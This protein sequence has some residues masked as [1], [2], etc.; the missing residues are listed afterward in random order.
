MATVRLR[1]AT[2]VACLLATLATAPA[3]MRGKSTHV[4]LPADLS[5][6]H[7]GSAYR[8]RVP[9]NWNGTLLVYAHGTRLR[10]VSGPVV[11]EIAPPPY[12][13]PA[14][15][16]EDQLLARGYALAG[17]EYASSVTNGT[18]ATH[19]LTEYFNGAVGRPSRVLIWGCSLGGTVTTLLV[20]KYPN[21]YDGGVSCASGSN[22]MKAND[23][24]LAF[25]LAYDV[26]FG[27]PADQWGPLEDVRDDL[28]F[29]QDVAPIFKTQ[30]PVTPDKLAKWEFIRLVTKFSQNAFW[31]ADP[32]L[33]VQFFALALWRA[34]EQRANAEAAFGGP[35]SQN[36]DHVYTLTAGEKAYLASL[37]MTNAD[38]LLAEMNA[39]TNIEAD[40]STRR[41]Q[42]IWSA[43]GVLTRPL[44]TM[45]SAYDGLARTEAENLFLAE[46]LR[47]GRQDSLVQ[48]YTALPG[49]CSFSTE[50]LLAALGALEH[51]IDTGGRP[52]ASHFPAS[53]GFMQGFVPPRWPF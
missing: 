3:A 6:T 45:H 42:E 8:I 17:A 14:T 26:T 27:W 34:T 39:H 49:H 37:G 29:A 41:L 20:E 15:S 23:A 25:G 18:R 53:I 40:Q 1:V 2:L 50:Q 47:A 31:K 9:P 43:D 22:L 51:W 7:A 12:P 5:G 16:F 36:V 38:A 44:I 48:V 33:G 52:D 32:Q 4:Q 13:V 35:V 30:L 24:S 11:P 10:A 21:I 46:V 19:A 28:T